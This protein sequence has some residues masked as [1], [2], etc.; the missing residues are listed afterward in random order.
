MQL[1]KQAKLAKLIVQ[2][3]VVGAIV[4]LAVISLDE[5]TASFVCIQIFNASKLLGYLEDAMMAQQDAPMVGQGDH[6]N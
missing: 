2:R 5:A 1:P 3:G 4:P 6:I